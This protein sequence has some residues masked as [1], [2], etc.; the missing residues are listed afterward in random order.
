MGPVFPLS[1]PWAHSPGC[2]SL[3][4]LSPGLPSPRTV[5]SLWAGTVSSSPHGGKSCPGRGGGESCSLAPESK[6]QEWWLW[7][8]L[9]QATFSQP[10]LLSSAECL[11]PPG[12]ASQG[13][14]E[15]SVRFGTFSR[16][17]FC[18][19]PVPHALSSQVPPF[20]YIVHSHFP[21]ESLDSIKSYYNLVPPSL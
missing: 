15:T 9:R 1:A 3:S 10:A 7:G 19:Q 4:T 12:P 16:A 21:S 6:N 5:I 17:W 8:N 11:F 18:S 2:S 13:P 14:I 20:N